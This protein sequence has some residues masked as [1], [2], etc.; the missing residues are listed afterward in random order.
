MQER[1]FIENQRMAPV[2]E[3]SPSDR[4]LLKDAA[5]ATVTI[6]ATDIPTYKYVG[7]DIA[8]STYG[9]PLGKFASGGYITPQPDYLDALDLVIDQFGI[10][11]QYPD[12]KHFYDDLVAAKK[13]TDADAAVDRIRS[14]AWHLD[15][16][17]I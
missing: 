17:S 9:T 5:N 1:V 11:K 7:C 14:A 10:R 2:V 6:S 12:A 8:G 13:A 16:D 3:L 15:E 4:K